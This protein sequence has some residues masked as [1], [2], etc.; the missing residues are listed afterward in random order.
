M[1]GTLKMRVPFA[2]SAGVLVLIA[3]FI[4]VLILIL[5]LVLVVVLGTVL[6]AILVIHVF[7]LP[8]IICGK[9]ASIDCP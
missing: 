3:V 7:Y 4:L 9:T 6:V 1:N 5:V 2:L 8:K